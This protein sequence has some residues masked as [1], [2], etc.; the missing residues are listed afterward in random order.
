[1]DDGL[2]RGKKK[3]FKERVKHLAM[4]ALKTKKYESVEKKY[5]HK[6]HSDKRELSNKG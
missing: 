5:P 2:H 3:E 6:L 1:M 4:K